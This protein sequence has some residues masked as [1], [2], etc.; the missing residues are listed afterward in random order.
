MSKIDTF[1]EVVKLSSKGLKTKETIIAELKETIRLLKAEFS[2]KLQS[3]QAQSPEPKKE[4]VE[5]K[6]ELESQIKEII[7]SEISKNLEANK[8]LRKEAEKYLKDLNEN[9]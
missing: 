2:N 4:K 5:S 1:K 7:S 8:E 3:K 9:K 6:Q